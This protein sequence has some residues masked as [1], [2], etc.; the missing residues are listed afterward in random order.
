LGLEIDREQFCDDDYA[1]FAER[2]EDCLRVLAGLQLLG[3]P[4]RAT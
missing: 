1:R 2:L 4:M 3:S